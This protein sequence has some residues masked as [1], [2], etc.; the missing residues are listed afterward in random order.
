MKIPIVILNWNSFLDTKECIESILPYHNGGFHIYLMDNNSKEEELS[1]LKNAFSNIN[2]ITSVFY[3]ENLGFARAHN[4]MFKEL[5]T[6]GYPFI[7]V[8]NNDTFLP[9]DSLEKVKDYHLGTEVGMIAF[10]MQSYWDREKMDNAGHKML[11]SGEIIPIG[12]EEPIEAY[13]S[14]FE[15]MGA[16]AGATLYSVTM[17]QDIGVF[18]EYFETGYEDAELGLRAVVAGYKS[19]FN[20]EFIVFHKM[21]QSIKKVFNYNYTLKVQ[22][23]IFYTYLKLVHWQIIAIYFL[24]FILRFILITIVDIVFWRP[25]YL[26]VQYHALYIIL[27]KDWKRVMKARKESEKL[28][29]IN[30]RKLLRKQEFFLKRDIQSF[31]KFIIKGQKSYFEK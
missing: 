2:I 30:W 15:N 9:K 16:C 13:E 21:G 24:P 4:R 19:I 8:L 26:K 10:K 3:E 14:L 28:R 12:H 17:L 27:F 18:D 22:T 5:I 7:F 6:E 11:S 1:L 20:P 31:Y 23:N 25:K 29:R